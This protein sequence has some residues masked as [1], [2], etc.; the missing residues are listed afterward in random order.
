MCHYAPGHLYFLEFRWTARI[1]ILWALQQ[2]L[3]I[4]PTFKLRNCHHLGCYQYVQHCYGWVLILMI[5]CRLWNFLWKNCEFVTSSNTLGQ[6]ICSNSNSV[7]SPLTLWC[8]HL[9]SELHPDK[10]MIKIAICSTL[11]THFLMHYIYSHTI[12]NTENIK[13]FM[14]ASCLNLLKSFHYY[15]VSM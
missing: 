15:P 10:R 13:V 14:R 3:A 12:R 7:H 8:V 2:M 6:Y 4:L 5:S 9:S 11:L 1:T